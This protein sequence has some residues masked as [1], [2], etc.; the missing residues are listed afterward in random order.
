MKRNNL[1][2]VALA[3]IFFLPSLFFAQSSH[4]LIVTDADYINNTIMN[5]VN[6]DGSRKDL[7]RVY[8]LKRNTKYYYNGIIT[9][10]GW[11]LVMKSANGSGAKPIIVS[12]PDNLAAYPARMVAM[13]NHVTITGINYC[14]YD[15]EFNPND[16]STGTGQMI[17]ATSAGFDMKIDSCII[18]A[19]SVAQTTAACRLVKITNS[20]MGEMFMLAGSSDWGGGKCLDLR[21]GSCD[22]LVIQNCTF[23]NE[24]DRI[25]RHRAATVNL[26]N[27][28]FNHNT[29]INDYAYHGVI[30]LGISEK[31]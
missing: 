7:L 29:I 10:T 6:P 24:Q 20:T 21:N 13:Q 18:N 17:T 15:W 23:V 22:S 4:E 25:V 28:T 30:E 27:F 2:L 9:N 14:Y 11:P 19:R 8:V 5:D 31:K 16:V 12:A 1:L 3:L 26:S